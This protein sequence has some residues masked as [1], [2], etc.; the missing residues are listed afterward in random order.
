MLRI[1]VVSEDEK[2]VTLKLDG[3]LT[4]EYLT[5]LKRLCLSYKDEKS[6]TVALDFSEVTFIDDHGVNMLENI[7]DEHVTITNCSLFIETLLN[8]L[9]SGNKN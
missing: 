8:K 7:K 9:V 1:T 4:S 2:A 3:R 5:D 6:K